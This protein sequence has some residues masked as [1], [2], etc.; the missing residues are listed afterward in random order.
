MKKSNDNDKGSRSKIAKH[1][2][3]S[4]QRRQRQ[5]Q[6]LND[7]RNLIDLMKEC[8]NELT[9]REIVSL[10]ILSRTRKDDGDI[11]FIEMIKQDGDSHI[12]ELEVGEKARVGESEVEYFD[13]F[14]TRKGCPSNLKVSCNIRHVHAEKDCID[15]NSPLNVMTRMLYNWIMRR[16]LDP[17]ENTNEGVNNFIGRIKGMYVFVENFTYVIDF[18]IIEDISSIINPRTN[19]IAYKMPYKIEQYGSLSD[20]EIEQTKS[21]YIRNEEEKRRRVE[22]VMSKILRFYKECL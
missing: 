10:K 7:K 22:Y 16:K 5:R 17:S 20:L 12:E 18:M 6:E 14:L 9:S 8:H 1:E 4:L 21:V 2:G 11:M 3:T 19:E 13:I 15:L